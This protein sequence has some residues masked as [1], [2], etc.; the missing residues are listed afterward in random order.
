MRMAQ[1]MFAREEEDLKC[2]E[3]ARKLPR[4]SEARAALAIRSTL[5]NV[6]EKKKGIDTADERVV[7][8]ELFDFGHALRLRSR[9]STYLSIP[10]DQISH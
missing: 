9:S 5:I 10:S 7:K 6:I 8:P 3:L 1:D 4:Q 2:R